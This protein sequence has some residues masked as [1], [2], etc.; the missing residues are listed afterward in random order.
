MNDHK[1]A[2]ARAHRYRPGTTTAPE[3]ASTATPG[4]CQHLTPCP[5]ARRTRGR[6]LRLLGISAPIS[7]GIVCFFLR[8]AQS[9][10]PSQSAVTSNRHPHSRGKLL[11]SGG[12]RGGEAPASNGIVC[13]FLRTAQKKAAADRSAAACGI[14]LELGRNR[15]A[16][17]E[18]MEDIV[19]PANELHIQIDWYTVNRAPEVASRMVRSFFN[20]F[21]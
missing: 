8:T 12:A 15:F 5:K 16:G 11:S 20:S 7:N 4:I 1:T 6:H 21:M 3:S 18:L 9:G 13:F 2:G 19:Q 14:Y 10:S 17:M